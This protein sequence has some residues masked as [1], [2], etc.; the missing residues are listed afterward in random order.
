MLEILVIWGCLPEITND[1]IDMTN[2]SSTYLSILVGAIIG[3]AITWWIY[4]RQ[5]K[6]SDKQDVGLR[7]I[8]DLEESH[9]RILKSIE[10]FQK[11]QER[12]LNQILSLDKKIDS[13]IENKHT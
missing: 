1:C 4:N 3:L 6:I 5:K 7:H 12:I 11:H 2:A 10:G 8:K 13:A 9:E